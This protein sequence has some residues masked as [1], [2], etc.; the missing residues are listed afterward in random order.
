MT[1]QIG[2]IIRG[3]A[4]RDAMPFVVFTDFRDQI[5]FAKLA[6]GFNAVAHE[7]IAIPE[8]DV[9]G[10]TARFEGLFTLKDPASIELVP[11]TLDIG[12]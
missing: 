11:T 2:P 12:D 3:T 10:K 1:V 7:R 5:E 8:G 4:I 6:N 9:I